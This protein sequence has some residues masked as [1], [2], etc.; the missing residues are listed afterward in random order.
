MIKVGVTGGIGSGK[1]T[2][3]RLLTQHGAPL[4]VA[5]DE[6]KRLMQHDKG[7]REGIIAAF[8]EEAYTPEGLNRS[9]L[10]ERVFGDREALARLNGLVHPAVLADFE[11]WAEAHREHPYVIFESAILFSAGLAHVVD[12][13]VAVL[14]PEALRLERTCRRDGAEPEAVKRRMAAQMSDDELA[15]RADYA[16][17][18]IVEEELA[19]AADRLD[20]IFR[21]EASKA[22]S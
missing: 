1:S 21:H 20:K 5:D 6:A 12:F 11:R 10:A 19:A 2:L 15:E 3:C 18:N 13:T 16:V 14:A 9:W 22:H 4:Y 7:L 17:V 8:G